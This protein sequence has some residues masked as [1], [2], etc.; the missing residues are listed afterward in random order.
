MSDLHYTLRQLDWVLA[1]AGEHDLVVLAGDSLSIASIVEPDAQIAVVVELLGRMAAKTKVAI[2]SGN[3]D[4][5]GENEFGE[6]A[7]TWM[8]R[9]RDAGVLVD[10]M[11][12]EL[13]DELVT[14]C[15]WWDGP[16]TRDV[17]D[18]QLTRDAELRAGRR[19]TWVYHAPP[20]DSTTS[21]TGKRHYGDEA[22]SAWIAQHQPDY[23]LTGHVHQ[24]PFAK[25]GGW[26]DI[27][28]TTAVLNAGRQTGAI[29]TFIELDT[30]TAQASWRSWDGV[31]ERIARAG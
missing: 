1:V 31:D 19:W 21:W 3:H 23:V 4:L 22:L 13:D 8:G 11:R 27:I 2:A 28:G 26:C 5:D 16:R 29:P 9:A 6:R 17:V 20:E 25:G 14:V 7:A 12:W 18:A 15:P 30:A 24:S 10:G